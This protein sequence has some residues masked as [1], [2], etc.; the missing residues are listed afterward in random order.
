MAA[1][2][3]VCF[4]TA[5]FTLDELEAALES[6]RAASAERLLCR[7]HVALLRGQMQAS[8]AAAAAHATRSS[9]RHG[10]AVPAQ[11]WANPG[12]CAGLLL[13]YVNS[14]ISLSEE[15]WVQCTEARCAMPCHA[16]L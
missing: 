5:P 4:Q 8:R 3:F 12:G 7:L 1:L 14:K 2:L 15:T 11:M 10:C 6:P 13:Q 9:M 16:T